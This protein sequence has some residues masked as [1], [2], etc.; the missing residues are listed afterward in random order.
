MHGSKSNLLSLIESY[1]N[2]IINALAIYIAFLLACIFATPNESIYPTQIKPIII[3]IVLVII[4]SIVNQVISN[5][6]PTSSLS[7]HEATSNTIKTA[8]IIFSISITL[9]LLL[10]N[11]D[12]RFFLS[13]WALISNVISTLLIT[14]KNR[15][16]FRLLKFLRTK[17]LMLKRTII[18]GDNSVSVKDYVV[19]IANQPNS[20][21][22][23]LGCVGDKIECDVGCEK[24]GAFKDFVKILD[25]Y[26]PTDV[27]FAIDSYDKRHLIKLVNICD[28][29]CIRVSFLPVIY[30]FFKH[31]KQIEQVGT[32][33]VIN[34]H[35]NP[36][37]N[38]FNAF[39]KRSIDVIGSL[40]LI[41][42]T[43]PIMLAVIIGIKLTSDGPILFKQERVG[44]MG[45]T[46]TMFKFRSMPVNRDTETNWSA[47]G[48][49]RPTRFGSFIRRTAI[50]ELPQFFNVLMGQMSL[51]GPRPE[52]PKY[53]KEFRET[54]PLYMIKHYVKPGITGLAQIKGLRGDTSLEE[55]IHEDINYI[56]NWSIFLDIMILIKTP[57][58]AFNKYERYVK[59]ERKHSGIIGALQEKFKKRGEEDV[60]KKKEHQ[61]ILYAASTMSH[62]TSFHEKYIAKLREDGHDVYV[63][64]SGEG[65]DFNIPFEKKTFSKQNIECKKIISEIVEK[66]NFDLI[67]LNTSLAAF[68]I[69][70]ALKRKQRPRVVNIVHGYLFSE[71]PKGFKDRLKASMLLCAEKF[72]RKKTDAILTMNDEDFRIATMNNLTKGPIIPT[73]G[74][75]IPEPDFS[76]ISTEGLRKKYSNQD[77]FIMLFAG[78]LSA[79]KN[80]KFLIEALPELKKTVPGARLWLLGDGDQM[81]NLK[82]TAEKLG[83]SDSVNF[84]GR[85]ENPT[86]YMFE[87]D[88]YVSASKSEGLP[89]NIVEAL[90]CEKTVLA[91]KVKGH[92]DILSSGAGI[93]FSLRSKKDFCEKAANIYNNKITV[94]ERKIYIGFKNFSEE[95]VF[96][97]T[98]AKI[99]EASLL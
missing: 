46:F 14:T 36:L 7:P 19:Q 33:P 37:N 45:K 66:E 28:D 82:M 63:M 47:P 26:R 95:S 44:Q 17:N 4:Q 65:A 13:V 1:V 24:L 10:G 51:V 52:M 48:D 71:S 97:D 38:K 99:K 40:I 23:I 64:A 43:S 57:F 75:G 20:G 81:E 29:R 62:I 58:K 80:Q 67:I 96:Y 16:V 31:T 15:I 50:D 78:E 85:K 39:L 69:R 61:K 54:I 30:G 88:L 72:L 8:V 70:M 11:P 34:A 86:D 35:V 83:V 49:A 93:L 60:P 79:R 3:I 98:Y 42:V 12:S 6:R 89:F 41:A 74:F 22:M 9:I 90:G 94:S 25:N 73:F 91:S 76:K 32:I 27:I 56:E 5:Y 92:T 18:V 21:V 68:V 87:C 77:D 55:R 53:V 2:M 84:F 59:R